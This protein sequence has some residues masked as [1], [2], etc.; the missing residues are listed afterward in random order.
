MNKNNLHKKMDYLLRTLITLTIYI[1]H[2]TQKRI[3]KDDL[4]VNPE[5]IW[6]KILEE[7][8]ANF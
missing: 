6:K 4:K 1:L 7:H 2:I 5:I 3:H 8:M